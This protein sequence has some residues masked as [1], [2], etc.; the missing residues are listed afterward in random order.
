MAEGHRAT[1]AARSV[2]DGREH[3][4]SLGASGA[5]VPRPRLRRRLPALSRRR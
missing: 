2:L 1:G 5:Q 4:G 3:D